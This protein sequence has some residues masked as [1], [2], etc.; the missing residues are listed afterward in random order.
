MSEEGLPKRMFEIGYEPAWIRRINSYFNLRWIDIIREAL[1]DEH[2]EMLADSQFRYVMQMGNHTFSVMF[3]HYFLSRQ[4][5]TEK[6]YELW[7]LFGGKPIRFA[8]EDIALVTGLNCAP[9]VEPT[10]FRPY[11]MQGKRKVNGKTK[12]AALWKSL[13]G[14]E[15]SPT[16]DLI[17]ERLVQGKKYK[18]LL[19]RFRLGLLLLVEGIVC[20]TCKHGLIRTETVELVGDVT[21]FLKY[22][23]GRE[24]FLL[25]VGTAKGRERSQYAQQSTAIQ[26]FAHAVV[27]VTVSCYPEIIVKPGTTDRIMD[28]DLSIEVTFL[29]KLLFKVWWN[30]ACM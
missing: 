28:D 10:K 1:E 17:F 19:T 29:L 24:S 15:E 26:G 23:W 2:L 27:L 7:W 22:P 11:T 3:V 16:T 14:K 25:T 8:I 30:D 20:P 13:F 18:D 6:E 5:V 4:L 9:V 12:D 21:E